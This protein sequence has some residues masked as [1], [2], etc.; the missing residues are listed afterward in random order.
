[1]QKKN[2]L[3]KRSTV[4]SMVRTER[5]KLVLYLKN[6]VVR[7]Y[8][9]KKDPLEMNDLARLP[10][11]RSIA[12]DLFS[13]LLEKQKETGDNQNVSTCFKTFFSEQ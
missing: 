6:N 9:I 5:Y 10:K 1:M 11:Y 7:L 8:D 4:L 3:K 2:A 13:I 12:D